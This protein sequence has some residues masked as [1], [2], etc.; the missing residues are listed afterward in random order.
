MAAKPKLTAV[1]IALGAALG[2]VVGVMAGHL[3]IWLALGV[4]IGVVIG[5]SYP[6]K[7]LDCPECAAVHRQ[8]ISGEL[9]ARRRT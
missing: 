9:Q 7:G 5:A 4:A 2:A 1:G 8:H 3:A 6:R